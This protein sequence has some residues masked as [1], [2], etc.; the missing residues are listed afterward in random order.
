VNRRPFVAVVE[1][2]ASSEFLFA[3]SGLLVALTA[4]AI[5]R[6]QLSRSR[7]AEASR[8]ITDILERAHT[9]E[10]D[11]KIAQ[12]ILLGEMTGARIRIS[13]AYRLPAGA[14]RRRP[15]TATAKATGSFLGAVTSLPVERHSLEGLC[16]A[17]TVLEN[18]YRRFRK[19]LSGFGDFII[20]VALLGTFM[21]LIAAL[22]IASSN[23]GTEYSSAAEQSAHMRSFIQALLATA[24]NKFW[25]SAIGIGCALAVQV[26]RFGFERPRH[27]ERLGDAFDRVLSDPETVQAWRLPGGAAE[28]M[29]T[30][31]ERMRDAINDRLSQVDIEPLNRAIAAT[32]EVIMAN[33]RDS[34]ISFSPTLPVR[35]SR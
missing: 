30:E 3:Y 9:G 12:L 29:G 31:S 7:E 22:S 16:P 24:A 32:A 27:I 33:A 28:E 10:Q 21:G 19:G 5:L 1:M 35:S 17:S 18:Q 26:Y 13:E 20:R 14:D 25:I 2:F 4:L 23:I 34:V 11:A 15:K 6:D 8:Q